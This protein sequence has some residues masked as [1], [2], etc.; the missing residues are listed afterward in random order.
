MINSMGLGAPWA[1]SYIEFQQKEL[2]SLRFIYQY[3]VTSLKNCLETIKHI[4]EDR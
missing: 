1:N 4:D 3:P 2:P